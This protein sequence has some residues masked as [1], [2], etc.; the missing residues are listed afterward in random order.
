MY[1]QRDA[2]GAVNG[3]FARSQAGYA[4]EWLDA[5]HPDL[6]RYRGLDLDG[7]KATRR[8]ALSAD[9]NAAITGGFESDALGS[10]HRYDSDLEAQ[11]NLVGAASLGAAVDYT[12][13]EV[14]TGTKGSVTHT[15]AQI[16]QV[17]KDG[18]AIKIALLA[19]YRAR[20]ADVEAAETEAEVEAVVW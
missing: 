1:V 17:L 7:R 12:C 4:E 5:D 6:L 2:T 15:A 3:V 8:A 20:V 10:A 16:K 13:T 19:Q 14:A 18:A 11:V 9:C